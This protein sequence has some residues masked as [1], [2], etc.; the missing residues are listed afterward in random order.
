MSGW[1]RFV[2]VY[3]VY[4]PTGDGTADNV[5]ISKSYDPTTHFETTCTDV[6]DIFK[7]GTGAPFDF[8]KITHLSL[9]DNE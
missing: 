3:D 8:S 5:F 2:K 4:S 7:R 6:L 9:E 1:L